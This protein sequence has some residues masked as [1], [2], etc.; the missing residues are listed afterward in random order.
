MGIRDKIINNVASGINGRE[1]HEIPDSL[2]NKPKPSDKPTVILD[3]DAIDVNESSEKVESVENNFD[4]AATPG[5]TV[6]GMDDFFDSDEP[7]QQDLLVD[8]SKNEEKPSSPKHEK[9]A[10]S[11]TL[12]NNV[13]DNNIEDKVKDSPKKVSSKQKE[14]ESSKDKKAKTSSKTKKPS[15][16]VKKNSDVNKEP[17]NIKT[18]QLYLVRKVD[19]DVIKITKDKFVIGKS[20]YSDYQV[21]QNNTVSR[22]HAI[23]HIVDG[24][25]YIEDNSS[26]NGTFIDGARIQA[27]IKNEL[28]VGQSVRMSDEIFEVKQ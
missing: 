6:L 5:T 15:K 2:L 17:A 7:E 20:K 18:T 23:V 24:K 19:G 27:N 12:K 9:K 25:Y 16:K 21:T 13:S 11:S 10:E 8:N 14:N 4:P 3:S 22:S 1:V 28:E 26:K